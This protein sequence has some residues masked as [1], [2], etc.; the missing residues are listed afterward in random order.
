MRNRER[1]RG[2]ERKEAKYYMRES[3]SEGHRREIDRK[4]E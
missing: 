2:R 3:D 1:E 4:N